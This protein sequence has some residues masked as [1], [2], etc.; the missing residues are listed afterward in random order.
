MHKSTRPIQKML[1]INI[2]MSGPDMFI[3]KQ[4]KTKSNRTQVVS[5]LPTGLVM[6]VLYIIPE[7]IL[8]NLYR[9]RER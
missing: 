8:P 4:E 2:N 6:T 3:L 5:G 9:A 7:N 1:C